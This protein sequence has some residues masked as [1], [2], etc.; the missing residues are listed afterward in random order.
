MR[1]SNS[2][3]FSNH[4]YVPKNKCMSLRTVYYF[5]INYS[6]V[7]FHIISH[8][9]IPLK[10][11]ILSV[12][13]ICLQTLCLNAVFYSHITDCDLQ[14][15]F[16]RVSLE[17]RQCSTSVDAKLTS[18]PIYPTEKR[19]IISFLGLYIPESLV[20]AVVFKCVSDIPT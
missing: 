5:H 19:L 15:P 12:P 7:I 6:Y 18:P 13:N 3:G 16:W 10:W 11:T 17:G 14:N 4:E 1:F 2:L 8:L 20:L 9:I